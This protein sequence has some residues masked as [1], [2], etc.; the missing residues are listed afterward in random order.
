MS[1]EGRDEGGESDEDSNSSLSEFSK[2]KRAQEQPTNVDFDKFTKRQK[3]SYLQK[4]NPAT[5]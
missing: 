1:E 5:M 4:N 3:M 2:I